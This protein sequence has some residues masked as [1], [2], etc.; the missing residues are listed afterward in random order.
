MQ[1]YRVTQEYWLTRASSL[2][3]RVDEE[4]MSRNPLFR[5]FSQLDD[6]VGAAK[7]AFRV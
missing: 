3:K 5:H 4:K 1:Y 2:R 6:S 7:T